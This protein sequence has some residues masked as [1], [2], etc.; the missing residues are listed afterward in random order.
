M[1]CLDREFP[2]LGELPSN[3]L[4]PIRHRLSSASYDGAL[5]GRLCPALSTSSLA[6]G[7]L[8]GPSLSHI[9]VAV[10]I[11][12]K[13]ESKNRRAPVLNAL[14]CTSSCVAFQ[15]H[16][17]PGT[18]GNTEHVDSLEILSWLQFPAR[19]WPW[20][21]SHQLHVGLDLIFLFFYENAS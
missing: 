11:A 17:P 3:E 5:V 6:F 16:M 20:P 14:R 19:L 13:S 21:Q 1:R 9:A 7:R 12:C 4:A 10:A 8:Q 15:Q 18:K 2:W